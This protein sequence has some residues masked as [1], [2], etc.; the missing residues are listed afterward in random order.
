[1]N[2]EREQPLEEIFKYQGKK[3]AE[4]LECPRMSEEDEAFEFAER[5]IELRKGENERPR[6]K[7]Q[8][9]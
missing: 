9:L 4:K 6:S 5:M 2:L 3:C 7:K 1:M 8:I